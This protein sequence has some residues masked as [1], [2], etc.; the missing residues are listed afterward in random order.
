MR[1]P[2]VPRIHHVPLGEASVSDQPASRAAAVV[3]PSPSNRLTQIVS[4]KASDARERA[5]SRRARQGDRSRDSGRGGTHHHPSTM[6][7]PHLRRRHKFLGDREEAEQQILSGVTGVSGRDALRMPNRVSIK[8][9]AHRR[10]D[11]PTNV[12]RGLDWNWQTFRWTG[13]GR[14]E[15]RFLLLVVEEA[16]PRHAT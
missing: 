2:C 14:R 5:D 10:K 12:A 13:G 8:A 16:A 1:A 15:E 4:R 7:W 11:R 3:R 9:R 6:Q